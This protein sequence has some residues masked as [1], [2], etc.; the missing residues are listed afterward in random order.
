MHHTNTC[1]QAYIH[2]HTSNKWQQ[3]PIAKHVIGIC[4][5]KQYVSLEIDRK[6]ERRG[7]GRR[8]REREERGEMRGERGEG[9]EGVRGRRRNSRRYADERTGSSTTDARGP[10]QPVR[11]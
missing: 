2:T 4:L 6:R 8:E 10:R 9:R 11:G 5:T 7:E 1:I 3:E